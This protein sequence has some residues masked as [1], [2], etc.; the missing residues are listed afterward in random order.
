[1]IQEI[2]LNFLKEKGGSILWPKS[3]TNSVNK[4]KDG[5]VR[6]IAIL[7]TASQDICIINVNKKVMPTC[8]TD[9]QF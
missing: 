4:L 3:W 7:V 6:V 5:D 2:V 8:K 9:S 1:M